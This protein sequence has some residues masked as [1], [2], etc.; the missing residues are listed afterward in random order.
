MVSRGN[1]AELFTRIRDDFARGAA[2]G[3][4]GVAATADGTVGV[5]SLDTGER[6]AA[7]ETGGPLIAFTMRISEMIAAAGTSNG[8]VV[9]LD[10][11]DRRVVN[12]VSVAVGAS[13]T[14]ALAP[15]GARVGIGDDDAVEV[16]KADTSESLWRWRYSGKRDSAP[17]VRIAFSADGARLAALHERSP[18]GFGPVL[19]W[20]AETGE[21]RSRYLTRERATC[22]AFSPDG[23]RL[24]VGTE[25]RNLHLVDPHTLELVRVME[26]HT[27]PIEA[28]TF[29]PDG[30]MIASSSDDG[31]IRVRESDTATGEELARVEH[32]DDD[33]RLRW[34]YTPGLRFSPRHAVSHDGLLAA[35]CPNAADSLPSSAVALVRTADAV[36]FGELVHDRPVRS[37]AFSPDDRRM[38]TACDDGD[39]WVWDVATRAVLAVLRGHADGAYFADFSPDGRRI[40]SGSNDNTVRIWDAAS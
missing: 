38:V 40:A 3:L 37:V 18:R 25:T 35:K 11:A 19:V 2:G 27:R 16:L 6:V 34:M 32:R 14:I 22:V 23:L 21:S 26:G 9:I 5:W 1:R 7:I 20:D 28:V 33:D 39:V 24:A 29:S 4:S 17:F 30:S 13:S 15:D 12:R 8:N 10:L 36:E 31:T